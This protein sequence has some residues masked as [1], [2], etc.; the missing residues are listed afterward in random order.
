M[1][2][3]P[4]TPDEKKKIVDLVINHVEEN[5]SCRAGW[6][7]EQI[8]GIKQQNHIHDKIAGLVTRTGKYLKERNE[9]FPKDWKIYRNPNYEFVEISKRTSIVQRIAL[10]IT[11]GI[12]ILTLG[13]SALNYNLTKSNQETQKDIQKQIYNLTPPTIKIDSVIINQKVDSNKN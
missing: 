8:T 5:G 4:L 3:I 7:A 2:E 12:S 10:Y 11:I 13:I 6:A 1:G 9:H